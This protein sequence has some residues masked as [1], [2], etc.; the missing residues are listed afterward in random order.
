MSG[1]TTQVITPR[2][3]I[4]LVLVSMLSLLAYFAASGPHRNRD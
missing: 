4:G 1:D 3:A 2:V